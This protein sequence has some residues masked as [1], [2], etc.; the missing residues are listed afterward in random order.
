MSKDNN[1][2]KENA[3]ENREYDERLDFYSE[4]FDP[5]F[6]LSMEKNKVPIYSVKI[7]DNLSAYKRAKDVESK[8]ELAQKE[9]KAGTSKES[10]NQ[11]PGQ[12]RFLPHQSEYI[13]VVGERGGFIISKHSICVRYYFIFM[14]FNLQFFP[15]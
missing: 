5:L 13:S 9:P 8:P 7:Y 1:K 11:Q 15:K 2:E 10:E 12:R 6:A 3:D 14:R 4:K